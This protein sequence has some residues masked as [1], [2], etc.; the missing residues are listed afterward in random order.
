MGDSMVV[1]GDSAMIKV[2][3]HVHDPGIPISYGVKLGVISDVVVENMQTQSEGYIARREGQAEAPADGADPAQESASDVKPGEIAVVAVAPGNGLR[4]VLRDLG[5]TSVVSGG[6]TMNP[7]TEELLKAVEAIHTDKVILLPNNGNILMAA[8]QAA[9]LAGQQTTQRVTVIPT[10]TIPQGIAAMLSFNPGGDFEAVTQAMT[11]AT[12]HVVTGEVTTATRSVE[13]DGV[14]VKAGQVIGLVDGKLA[15]SGRDLPTVVRSLLKKMHAG[16]REIITL[17]YGDH[18]SE[19]EANT[20]AGELR[21]AYP[22]QEFD[23][24]QGGQPYY[25]YIVSAE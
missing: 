18:V 5:V 2:H 11:Q 8:Q 14:K 16:E 13:L 22:G 15:V 4:R 19:G 1:V 7:S 9:Q 21:G 12:G 23:V 17:Y 3:I 24:I 25:H 10:Q 20:L 6:Q